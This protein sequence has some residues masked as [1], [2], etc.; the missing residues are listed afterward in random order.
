[1]LGPPAYPSS[2]S[3]RICISLTS[4]SCIVSPQSP[5]PLLSCLLLPAHRLPRPYTRQPAKSGKT[6]NKIKKDPPNLAHIHPS[7]LRTRM[8]SNWNP[9]SIPLC[10]GLPKLPFGKS[11][12]NTGGGNLANLASISWV[13][14]HCPL[15][16]I[17]SSQPGTIALQCMRSGYV[18][19]VQLTGVP[20]ST[21]HV[22]LC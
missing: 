2:L 21:L 8:R 10:P 17:L 14:P 15:N 18:R 7:L 13:Q 11:L 22:Y 4:Q 3:G 19:S 16:P 1:M 6:K 20:S 5:D 9:T 12:F